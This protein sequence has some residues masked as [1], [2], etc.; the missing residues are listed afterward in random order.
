MSV[1][2]GLIEIITQTGCCDEPIGLAV[3]ISDTLNADS[4]RRMVS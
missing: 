2:P 4:V 3:G 1:S